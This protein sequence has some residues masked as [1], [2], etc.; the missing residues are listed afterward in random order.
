MS[1]SDEKIERHQLSNDGGP[2][3]PIPIGDGCLL[4]RGAAQSTNALKTTKE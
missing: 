2:P 1:V 4:V 3:P